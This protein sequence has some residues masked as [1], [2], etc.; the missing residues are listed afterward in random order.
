MDFSINVSEIDLTKNS[1]ILIICKIKNYL[2]FFYN[3][4]SQFTLHFPS[5]GNI[6]EK[7]YLLIK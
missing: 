6:D 1:L 4:P 7:L 2:I 5:W 3:S